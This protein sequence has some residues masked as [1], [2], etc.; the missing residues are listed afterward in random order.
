[1][2]DIY[3]CIVQQIIFVGYIVLQLQF[4]VRVML[5]P[6]YYYYRVDVSKTCSCD[7]MVS[8]ATS[9]L[10]HSCEWTFS[11]SHN[12]LLC[13]ILFTEVFELIRFYS[14]RWKEVGE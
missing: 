7:V 12:S 5:F 11:V 3:N 9:I 6:M 10:P 13:G 1:M 14:V 2:Q 8:T 4:T